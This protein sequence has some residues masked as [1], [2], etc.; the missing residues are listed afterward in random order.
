MVIA[1][2]RH[3][4]VQPGRVV[5]HGKHQV[6]ESDQ[7]D[8]SPGQARRPVEAAADANGQD[9][10]ENVFQ[11]R[12][13]GQRALSVHRRRPVTELLQVPVQ[14]LHRRVP[15]VAPQTVR[16]VAVCLSDTD[17]KVAQGH[18]PVAVDP[19]LDDVVIPDDL[20]LEDER[21]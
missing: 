21:A 5:V 13:P 17:P 8:G 9:A 20:V 19:W 15:Y 6:P 11:M 18:D 1:Q 12:L 7:V 14:V 2:E 10:V 16:V 3:Q 4:A